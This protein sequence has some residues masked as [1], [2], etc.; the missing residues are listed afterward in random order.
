MQGSRLV[1]LII[2]P[3]GPHVIEDGKQI[4]QM[5]Q[6]DRT[7][8]EECKD[9][10]DNNTGILLFYFLLINKINCWSTSRCGI[11]ICWKKSNNKLNFSQSK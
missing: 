8:V 2:N 9:V 5:I 10:Y 4:R 1:P 3:D 6:I 7:T 11:F